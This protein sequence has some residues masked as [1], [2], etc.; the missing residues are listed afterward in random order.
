VTTRLP[1][2]IDPDDPRAPTE[3]VWQRLSN[4]ERARVVDALPSEIPSATPPEGDRHRLASHGPLGALQ[5]FFERIGRKMYLSSNLPVYY[6]GER[7]FAPD[8][9][10]VADVEP[11]ERD[12]WVVSAE[13]KGLDLALEVLYRGDD[14][15]DLEANVE[16][17]A[18]LGIDEY[19]IYDR[20]RN[21]LSG[22][23]LSSPDARSYQPIVPQQGRW[24]SRVLGLE[25]ALESERVRL[26]YG[27]APL[28]ELLEL[29][30]RGEAL[31]AEAMS[32]V[33]AAERQAEAEA[34]RAED[35]ARRAED[36]ARRAEDEAR[37]ATAAERELAALRAEIERLRKNK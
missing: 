13:G 29:A 14:R 10:A 35:E 22:Y 3:E 34:R 30:R 2:E 9:I 4:E 20:K 37:R 12:R 6:P 16:R 28:P 23:A 26:Y 24:A 5:A 11:H 21:R 15:K 8:V 36:E 1:V 33:E 27:T 7:M 31:L 19:F 32:R 18:K 25:L 17:Y